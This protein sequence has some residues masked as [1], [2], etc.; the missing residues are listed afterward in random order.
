[1]DRSI[2]V[3]YSYVGHSS[4]FTVD[5]GGHTVEALSGLRQNY[6]EERSNDRRSEREASQ[7]STAD[8]EPGRL[9]QLIR[10][11]REP[12]CLKR[13]S[14]VARRILEELGNSDE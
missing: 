7:G 6:R 2:K 3:A 13:A 12:C 8:S 5:G 9:I 14:K 10:E 4:E 1:M 11:R